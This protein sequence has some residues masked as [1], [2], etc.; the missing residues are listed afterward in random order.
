MKKIICLL[1]ILVQVALFNSCLENKSQSNIKKS[2]KRDNTNL[3]P[4]IKDNL[5]KK[6]YLDIDGDG[7]INEQDKP[8]LFGENFVDWPSF[9]LQSKAKF[10]FHGKYL[11]QP[12]QS[13]ALSADI[14][15]NNFE[16]NFLKEIFQNGLINFFKEE[17]FQTLSLSIP[18]PINVPNPSQDLFN[19]KSIKNE[20]FLA[21]INQWGGIFIPEKLKTVLIIDFIEIEI[22]F[23]TSTNI[24]KYFKKISGDILW[25]K[26][27]TSWEF[28]K[29]EFDKVII[30]LDSNVQEYINFLTNPTTL[31]NLRINQWTIESETE[32]ETEG[33]EIVK[34]ISD[35]N[36]LQSLIILSKANQYIT[37]TRLIPDTEKLLVENQNFNFE[38][39]LKFLRFNSFINSTNNSD[40]KNNQN[41]SSI[42]IGIA[43]DS[44][45][46]ELFNDKKN[47]R[48]LIKT[49][50]LKDHENGTSEIIN[51]QSLPNKLNASIVLTLN[52]KIH[53]L[54]TYK[55]TIQK[56]FCEWVYDTGKIIELTSD[57]KNFTFL[58]NI[59]INYQP[60]KYLIE[61]NEIAIINQSEFQNEKL[62]NKFQIYWRDNFEF[63]SWFFTPVV[64]STYK[65]LKQF[66]PYCFGPAHI[67]QARK[68]SWVDSV[69]VDISYDVVAEFK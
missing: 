42:L 7:F 51:L 21:E 69:D 25:N 37:Y 30:K 50:L 1:I 68:Y 38:H 6:N 55:K 63:N 36:D 2:P 39:S 23:A 29:N 32:K 35:F 41:Q 60:I 22:D 24:K 67:Q 44:S 4:Q 17:L 5:N 19:F 45:D 58:N 14:I 66:R 10:I 43:L 31:L 3:E 26:N 57:I 15:G 20:L 49:N 8:E 18:L 33:F 46:L 13:K 27:V 40:K 53:K 11:G 48:M 56:H 52:R 61:S 47:D 28:K 34:K 9:L 64:K 12:F 59:F 16:N 54:T 65:N 62:I